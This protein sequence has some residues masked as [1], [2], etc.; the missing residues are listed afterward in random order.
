MLTIKIKYVVLVKGLK[1]DTRKIMVLKGEIPLL[2]LHTHTHTHTVWVYTTEIKS[3]KDL[4][5]LLLEND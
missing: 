5:W 4:Y 3:L 1:Y 2:L